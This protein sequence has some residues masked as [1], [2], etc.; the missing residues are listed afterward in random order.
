MIAN[1][2]NADALLAQASRVVATRL[3]LEFP[4]ER[5]LE[6]E[7][8][9]HAAARA[10]GH[11]DAFSCM[12]WL[13]SSA[14][15][16]QEIEQLAAHLTVAE[17]Y[18][19]RDPATLAALEAYVLPELLYARRQE[20]RLRLWSAG[21]ATGEEPYTLAILLHRLL[22]GQ[23][24][25]NITILGSDIHAAALE[26][27]RAGIYGEWSFRGTPPWLK[28]LYFEPRPGR[29][30]ALRQ[31][32]QRM[33]SFACLNLAD[34]AYPSLTTN[35][36]AMDLVVCRNVLMYF[37]PGRARQVV[38]RLYRS[39][40]DGGW[41]I[42]SPCEA[43]PTVLEGFACLHWN[44]ALLYRKVA[45][46][47]T[48]PMAVPWAPTPQEPLPADV[49]LEI[50]AVTPPAD[51]PGADVLP[52][53]APSAAPT[54]YDHALR[55]CD[56]GDYAAARAELE[57]LLQANGRD[58]RAAALLARVC[59]NQGRLTEA[60]ARCDHAL[61]CDKL[62]PAFH[63][64]RAIIL[65]ESGEAFEA[66]AALQRALYLDQDFVMA[67]FTLGVVADRLGRE[68]LARRHRRAALFLLRGY[69]EAAIV[70]ASEGISAGRLAQIIRR[71][72]GTA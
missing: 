37:S 68:R 56:A 3:G 7:R 41:L 11:P 33:V 57:S 69:E 47:A 72:E 5:W 59:A 60:L 54:A 55:L 42:V 71:Q 21:C 36:N 34:D 32:V 23:E 30:F 14:P 43:S 52:P 65:E 48:S 45:Q 50:L 15:S 49:P 22:H 8:A 29:R 61:A 2:T 31:H 1:N 44:G 64:L 24:G 4:P 17:T 25:W 51:E 27:A 70:P 18:F 10:L 62:Q 9:M 38:Q 46:A 20:R 13:C 40:V 12:S 16:Q 19:F 35:T 53:P 39:L 6:L 63:Y 58:A 67:H 28:P 26:K 66:L